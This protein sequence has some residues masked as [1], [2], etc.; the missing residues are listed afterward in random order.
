MSNKKY[1]LVAWIEK[2]ELRM[3]PSLVN[4]ASEPY[5]ERIEQLE[6]RWEDV[7]D[8]MGWLLSRSRAHERFARFLLRVGYQREAYEE[9]KNAAMVCAYC[10]D[11]LWL[12]SES[13]DF[14]ALPLLYRFLSMHRQCVRL[15]LKDEYLRNRYKNS[16]LESHYL[17][18]TLDDQ[19]TEREFSEIYESMRVWQF[20]KVG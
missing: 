12:Q 9:Y 17:Y 4:I 20:G 6:A 7:E 1:A 11:E 10:S 2:G 8:E 3:V 14:P 16:D 18:F 5:R 19:I 13:C 15:A